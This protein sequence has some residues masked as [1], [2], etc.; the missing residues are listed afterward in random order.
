MKKLRF[1]KVSRR[2]ALTF[3]GVFFLA[4]V[5]ILFSRWLRTLPAVIDFTSR[6]PGQAPLPKGAPVGL[7]AWLGW[8]HF[9]NAFF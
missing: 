1:P 6:Y 2:G 8:Q 4:V 5:L 9:F 7:P 3:V